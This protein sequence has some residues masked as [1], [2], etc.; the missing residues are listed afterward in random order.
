MYDISIIIPHY[1]NPGLLEHLLDSI[2]DHPNVQIIVIDD[3]SNIALE[4]LENIKRK[5]AGWCSFLDNTTAIKGAGVCRNIGLDHAVGKWLLFSDADDLFLNDWYCVIKPY[6]ESDKDVVYFKPT[7]KIGERKGTRH[8]AY[9]KTVE[10]YIEKKPDSEL[11]LRVKFVTPWSKMIK[12]QLVSDNG[13]RFSETLYA[14]DVLFSSKVGIMAKTIQASSDTFYC[15]RDSEGTLTKNKK[16]EA[17]YIRQQVFCETYHFLKSNLPEKEFRKTYVNNVPAATLVTLIRKKYK[18]A[19]IISMIS[20]YRN[21]KIPLIV[22]GNYQPNK[23]RKY[24]VD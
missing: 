21:N 22:P 8:V 18:L 11:T 20:L 9:A 12:R 16:F 10:D 1:N 3:K 4:K 6:L 24:L 14:N 17:I 23:I 15:V 19:D 7:S 13:I 2:G 5:F